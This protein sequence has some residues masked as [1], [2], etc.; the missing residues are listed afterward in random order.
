MKVINQDQGDNWAVYHGDS[1]EVIKGIP[2]N[3][4]HFSVFSPPFESLYTYSNSERDLGNSKTSKEFTKHFRF[5]VKEI[6][7][8]M[9]PGRNVSVHCMDLPK[10]KQRDGV[11]GLRDFRG[12]LIRI[13]ER[14][15]FVFHSN[16]TIW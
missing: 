14:A 15:G 5:L 4:I 10:S 6:H 7:R 2:D 8:I 3:S 9:M 12:S 16:V 13:F 1:C 11:I